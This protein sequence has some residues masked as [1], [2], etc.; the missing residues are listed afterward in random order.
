MN[1]QKRLVLAGC[2]KWDV[3]TELDVH[4]GDSFVCAAAACGCSTM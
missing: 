1:V 3:S 4:R 2:R